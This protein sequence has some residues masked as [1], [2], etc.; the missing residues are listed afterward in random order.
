M[1]VGRSKN[2]EGPYLDNRGIDMI[3]GGGVP[4]IEGDKVNYEAAGHC[5]AYHYGDKDIFI[6]HGYKIPDGESVLVI[7]QIVWQDGWPELS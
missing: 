3:W 5:A 1:V 4:V 6:C 2:I 7:R